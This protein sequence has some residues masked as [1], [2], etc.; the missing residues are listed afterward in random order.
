[1]KIYIA[2]PMRGKPRYNFPAFDHAA[3]IIRAA[4]HEP[5]S[6]ADRARS[7]GVDPAHLEDD[8]DYNQ[9]PEGAS[10]R[11]LMTA[12]F[13]DLL[14]CDAI[15]LLDGWQ[16]SGWAPIEAAAAKQAGLKR[17]D[18]FRSDYLHGLL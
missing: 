11:A 16:E 7:M 4:G 8:W 5:V 9:E 3:G 13:A 17:L 10:V 14:T 1:M 2:G 12:N 15:I 18:T 6:P